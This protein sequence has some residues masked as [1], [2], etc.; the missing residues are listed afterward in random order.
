MIN[1][2]MKDAGWHIVAMFIAL[3]GTAAL[4]QPLTGP[5]VAANVSPTTTQAPAASNPLTPSS[6]T[7]MQPTT[8]TS[9]T[10]PPVPPLVPSPAPAPATP[11]T[12]QPAPQG[13]SN[14]APAQSGGGALNLGSQPAQAPSQQCAPTTPCGSLAEA[15]V[16]ARKDRRYLSRMENGPTSKVRSALRA[17]AQAILRGWRNP[18]FHA[19]EAVVSLRADC[20]TAGIVPRSIGLPDDM[21][22]MIER[23]RPTVSGRWVE[24]WETAQSC[25]SAAG[26]GT[27][28]STAEVREASCITHEV[29]QHIGRGVGLNGHLRKNEL[30]EKDFE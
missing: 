27:T 1:R 4:A 12:A 29:Y 6:S 14:L 2:L 25:L 7:S 17:R 5:P 11:P 8:G 30:N 20:D 13:Q 10:T 16:K 15:L 3:M 28:T 18:W 23:V 22:D 9:T 24:Q 19:E 26:S 21:L